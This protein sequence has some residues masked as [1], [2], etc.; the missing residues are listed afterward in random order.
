MHISCLHTRAFPL[1]PIGL[2]CG[3]NSAEGGRCKV[4]NSPSCRSPE[5]LVL[6]QHS[7]ES[8]AQTNDPFLSLS[9]VNRP[10]PYDGDCHTLQEGGSLLKGVAEVNRTDS[11]CEDG[12]GQ[13]AADN[14]IIKSG[15]DSASGFQLYLLTDTVFSSCEQ[16]KLCIGV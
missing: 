6:V 8:E 4:K 16:E 7:S 3:V 15:T 13:G 2:I 11:W 1:D 9:H 5:I 14:I 12:G 10:L